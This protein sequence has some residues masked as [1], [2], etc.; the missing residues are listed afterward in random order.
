M[1]GVGLRLQDFFFFNFPGGKPVLRM[2]EID[3]EFSTFDVHINH[4][5]EDEVKL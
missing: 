1:S 2:A 5:D 3:Q 4:L